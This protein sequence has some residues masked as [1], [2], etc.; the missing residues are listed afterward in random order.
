VRSL[1]LRLAPGLHDVRLS[2]PPIA[3]W[4][5]R[6]VD[7]SS[8]FDQQVAAAL[9]SD[10][11]L[12]TVV[13]R[14]GAVSLAQPRVAA[15]GSD[16]LAVSL[17]ASRGAFDAPFAV[18]RLPLADPTLAGEP[19]IATTAAT[20]P[21]TGLEW[22][23]VAVADDA[24]RRHVRFRIVP[25]VGIGGYFELTPTSLLPNSAS[26]AARRIV[27]AYAVL[28]VHAAQ[29][30]TPARVEFALH[31]LRVSRSLPARAP[32]SGV[33][34]LPLRVDGRVAGAS[35]SLTPG[36]H[37]VS[38]AGGGALGV[39]RVRDERA[40]AAR[41]APLRVT[42]LSPVA[43]DVATEAA[44]P[45]FVLVLNESFHSEWR[46]TLDGRPLPHL[47]ANGFANGWVVPASRGAQRIE[48]RFTA[49]RTYVA[50]AWLSVLGGLACI[51]GLLWWRR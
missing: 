32:A 36:V 19:S 15:S 8:A 3:T 49:Q 44:S 22:L 46:A 18:V 33:G 31:D 47:I 42:A 7:P 13:P 41:P 28:G 45:G 20:F 43:F 34:A 4:S 1:S 30:R 2:T 11:S 26:D 51:G 27:G 6:D 29:A 12:S 35:V 39:L 16:A 50:T 9:D 17:P 21:V 24:S 14:G 48:L 23:A 40:P 5:A 10:L 38:A 37:S 25:N